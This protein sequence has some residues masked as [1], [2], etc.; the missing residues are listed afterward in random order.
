MRC[1][2]NLFQNICNRIHYVIELGLF[3]NVIPVNGVFKQYISS[4]N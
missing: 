3:K 2:E 1:E 4:T